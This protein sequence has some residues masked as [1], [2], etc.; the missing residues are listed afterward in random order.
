M[1]RATT[2]IIFPYIAHCGIFSKASIINF[3]SSTLHPI[4][5]SDR[6]I[7]IIS[8][9][10]AELFSEIF[11]LTPP[12]TIAALYLHL[13]FLLTHVCL[14]L[15]SLIMMY[16]V[17]SLHL[18]LR[19]WMTWQNS[20]CCSQKLSLCADSCLPDLGKLFCLSLSSHAFLSW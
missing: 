11:G 10:K 4:S 20:L 2:S 12:Y 8:I 9:A 17:A 19:N 18:K 1:Q 7:A 13:H 6:Y 16:Y 15:K 3:T 14:L 5:P